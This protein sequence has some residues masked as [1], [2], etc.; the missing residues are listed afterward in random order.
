MK[1]TYLFWGL[2]FMKKRHKIYLLIL[3]LITVIYFA[4][5]TILFLSE[6][7]NDHATIRSFSDA[8]WYSIVTLSTVGYGDLTPITPVGHFIGI[9]F[10]FLSA[11]ILVTLFGT[12]L[13]FLTGEALPLFLLGL[14]KSKNWYYFADYGPEAN[15]LAGNII[16]ED[17]DAVVIYGQKKD[18]QSEAPDYPCLFLD[19]SLHRIIEK[20]HHSGTRCK[21]FLMKEN[22]IGVNSRAVDLAFLPV[23]VYART[24]NGQDHLPGKIHFFHSYDCCARQ[25][26]H[27]KPLCTYEHSIVIIGFGHYGK[28]ILKRA[29]LTNI[30]STDQHVSYHIFGDAKHFLDIHYRLDAL[31][32]INKD[33]KETDSLIFHDD[34]WGKHGQILEQASRIIICDDNEQD[35][36]DIYWKLHSFYRIKGRIDLRSNRKAPGISYFGTNEEIYTPE[37]ILRTKLNEAAITINDLFRKSVDYPTLDWDELDDFHRQ[38]K[39]V[40]ADHLLMKSRILLNDETINELTPSVLMMA[41]QR[42]TDTKERELDL[43]KYRKIEHLRW[44]RFYAYYNW[45]YGSRKN[46]ALRQHPMLRPY[47][48]LT[49]EQKKERDAAWELMNNISVEF[50][51]HLDALKTL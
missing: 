9:I 3:V 34:F 19:T 5:L 35:G 6:S 42:Y 31:F 32:S 40:A 10:L 46:D 13:S 30:I 49:F 16:K 48:E 14:L 45:S 18:E 21:V 20:K 33:S 11:G 47:H 4:L 25:Y 38:S 37:Q 1:T 17:S 43:E 22:D 24:T 12:I 23:D 27:A 44:L 15:T 26:W 8:F 41:Y 51:N 29:M 39:I 7:T 50:K 2:L 28:A 36:W